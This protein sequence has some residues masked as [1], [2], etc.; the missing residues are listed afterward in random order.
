MEIFNKIKAELELTSLLEKLHLEAQSDDAKEFGGLLE[1]ARAIAAPK[2]VYK[3]AYIDERQGDSV[4]IEGIR[5]NSHILRKNLEKVERVFAYVATCGTELDGIDIPKDDMLKQYWLDNIKSVALF[6]ARQ[7]LVEYLKNKYALG[8]TAAMAPGS[9]NIDV[10]PIEQ[11]KELFSV[12]GNVEEI[13]GV[14]LTESFLMIPNKS[15]SGIIFPT[16]INY[17]SCKLCTR[18]Q[19]PNR[20]APFDRKLSESYNK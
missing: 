1:T 11:Q 18:E 8:K 2:V 7:Y 5:F 10:W 17:V 12:F 20:R 9:G 16:E 6:S 14:K 13:I 3:T 15:V 4:T 19:C